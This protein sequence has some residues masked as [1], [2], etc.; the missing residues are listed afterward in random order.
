MLVSELF[1]NYTSLFNRGDISALG[2]LFHYPLTYYTEGGPR[3]YQDSEEFEPALNGIRLRYHRVGGVELDAISIDYRD[4]G[5]HYVAVEVLWILRDAGGK[6]LMHNRTTYMLHRSREGLSIVSVLVHDEQEKLDRL[7]TTG[8]AFSLAPPNQSGIGIKVERI[9]HLVLTVQSISRSVEF[10]T[11]VLGLSIVQTTK[12]RFA[13]GLGR[14]KLNL[15]EASAEAILPRAQTPTPGSADLCF[16]VQQSAE[17][18]EKWLTRQKVSVELGPVKRLGAL[19]EVN[20]VY[21]RDPDHN[22]IELA[23]YRRN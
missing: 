8:Q 5:E 13:L 18:V 20:S 1:Q 19:G 11:R 3:V 12:G 21:F 7:M 9:D 4:R 15:H 23:S 22:L 6:E 17:E 2:E 10:Y 14:Y 16:V